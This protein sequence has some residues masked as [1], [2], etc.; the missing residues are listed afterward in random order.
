[1]CKITI[2]ST[3]TLS[4]STVFSDSH[5][6]HSF[7]SLPHQYYHADCKEAKARQ[8]CSPSSCR[9][10]AILVLSGTRRVISGEV[11]RWNI[12]SYFRNCFRRF[13]VMVSTAR[14]WNCWID[15]GNANTWKENWKTDMRKVGDL[16]FSTWPLVGW[17]NLLLSEDPAPGI[18]RLSSVRWFAHNSLE[19]AGSGRC[20]CPRAAVK[21]GNEVELRATEI[22]CVA[23]WELNTSTVLYIGEKAFRNSTLK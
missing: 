13:P 20:S 11:S 6:A 12:N 5:Q 1:V 16:E 15:D 8:S 19:A 10:A 2:V 17:T 4:G 22:P 18:P 9:D 3:D 14:L 23:L 7:H 21:P